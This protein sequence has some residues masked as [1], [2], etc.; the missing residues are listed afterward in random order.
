MTVGHNFTESY[1]A[2]RNN[3]LYQ[4][5]LQGKP[6]AITN[7]TTILFISVVQSETCQTECHPST[8][9]ATTAIHQSL[10]A[11]TT[12][13][14]GSDCKHLTLRT[15]ESHR[16]WKKTV[17]MDGNGGEIVAGKVKLQVGG[18]RSHAERRTWH[19]R[20]ISRYCSGGTGIKITQKRQ[21][22]PSFLE[23]Y[24]N[25]RCFQRDYCDARVQPM[26]NDCSICI[27][28]YSQCKGS[29][30]DDFDWPK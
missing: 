27:H 12:A 6:F 13:G 30:R 29:K 2:S 24:W 10:V 8:A 1:S 23:I 11:D 17:M 20:S 26:N 18:V 25:Y 14:V 21:G 28:W 19:Q 9:N 22:Q 3:N 4:R 5:K 7:T 15:R 16:G